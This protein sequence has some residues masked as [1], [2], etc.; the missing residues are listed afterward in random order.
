MNLLHFTLKRIFESLFILFLVL[1]VSYIAIRMMKGSPFGDPLTSPYGSPQMSFEMMEYLETKLYYGKTP[2]AQFWTYLTIFL[3]KDDGGIS[4]V[5]F[6]GMSSWD[7]IWKKSTKTLEILFFT[8]IISYICSIILGRIDVKQE[9][10]W[11]D[12]LLRCSQ[13]FFYSIPVFFLAIFLQQLPIFPTG[14]YTSFQNIPIISG[15]GLFDSFI[16]SNFQIY[17]DILRHLILPILTLV[18]MNVASNFKHIREVMKNYSFMD[19]FS[20]SQ[21][22]KIES[23][24]RYLQDSRKLAIGISFKSFCMN[25]G[26]LFVGCFLVERAFSIDGMGN[27][28]IYAINT[29]DLFVVPT[30][31]VLITAIVLFINFIG[32]VVYLKFN[33]VISL[34]SS[35]VIGNFRK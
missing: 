5:L 35:I 18:I 30:L 32:D 22:K 34:K 6:P 27:L 23:H 33:P 29:R 3:S 12:W 1:I 25:T 13:M 10:K 14:G 11:V 19:D 17:M 21:A 4:F 8:F 15:F 31:M 9:K 2:L 20:T 7:L 26:N 24:S 16:T 28:I